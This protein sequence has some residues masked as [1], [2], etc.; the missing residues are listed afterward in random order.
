MLIELELVKDFLNVYHS[1]D[2]AKLELILEGAINE[3][4][5]II[6]RQIKFVPPNG[7]IPNQYQVY[8]EPEYVQA[9]YYEDQLSG[10]IAGVKMGVLLLAQA[11]YYATPDDAV[12]LRKA[13]EIK[14]W[15]YRYGLGV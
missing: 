1:A 14:L 5:Q 9:D 2:D 8:F 4:E 3:A 10:V 6:N 13:A 7:G 15:P 12:R 11:M